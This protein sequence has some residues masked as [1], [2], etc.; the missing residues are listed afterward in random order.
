MVILPLKRILMWL[1]H[2][3]LA[4]TTQVVLLFWSRQELSSVCD[5]YNAMFL[6]DCHR[7]LIT[8]ELLRRYLWLY[9]LSPH[10]SFKFYFCGGYS[11]H[12]SL[13]C[14]L[15]LLLFFRFMLE[16]VLVHTSIL[17][18]YVTMDRDISWAVHI[19]STSVFRYRKRPFKKHQQLAL[20]HR[21]IPKKEVLIIQYYTVLFILMFCTK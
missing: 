1:W 19:C 18:T 15:L 3:K 17:L 13:F 7:E 10:L 11:P 8:L 20:K 5:R 14:I 2:Q 16:N 4:W 9:F 12:T 21:L 6:P